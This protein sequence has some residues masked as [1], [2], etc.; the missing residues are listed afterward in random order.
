MDRPAKHMLD[1]HDK[2]TDTDNAGS[3]TAVARDGG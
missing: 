1:V 3:F 2:L